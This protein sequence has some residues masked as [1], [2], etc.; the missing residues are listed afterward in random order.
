M[1]PPF[2][3]H[4][5]DFIGSIEAPRGYDTVYGNNQHKLSKPVTKMTIAEIQAAQP[6][7]TKI[8]GSSATGRYQFMRDT[9]KGL[10]KELDL[11]T[12]AKFDAEMQDRLGFHLLRRR[13][14]DKYVAGSMGMTAFGRA[15]AQEWASLPVL[16]DT[17]GAHRRVVRGQ[18]YYA[19]DGLN[20]SLVT[21]ER[22]EAV[23]KADLEGLVV[24]APRP[25]PPKVES[26]PPLIVKRKR[27]LP[28]VVSPES[29]T[30]VVGGGGAAEAA[31]QGASWEVVVGILVA[32]ALIA[33]GIY[34]IRRWR[35]G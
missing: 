6:V 29:G 20:K 34:A 23:L 35:N 9:L 32:G 24:E 28:P 13:G 25:V 27:K 3:R 2:A 15:L 30:I 8:F 26:P 18:S 14:Y 10:I 16:A 33:L 17:E 19:G 7:W 21:P 11:D 5:L 4:L 12:S 31:R 1:I 22:V